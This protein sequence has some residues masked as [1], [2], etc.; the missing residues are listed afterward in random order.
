MKCEKSGLD[1]SRLQERR[2][3]NKIAMTT[4]QQE[5]E[6]SE[7]D[8]HGLDQEINHDVKSSKTMLGSET[9][10]KQQTVNLTPTQVQAEKQEGNVFPYPPDFKQIQERV[11]RFT[12]KPGEEDF[13]VWLADFCEATSDCKWSDVQRAQWFLW[14]LSGAAKST[15][16]RTLHKEEK[17]SWV[18][19]VRVYKGH[20]GVHMEP[21]TAYLRCHEL[22]YEDFLSVKGLLGSMKDYQRMA[23]EQLSDDNLLS[24]LW[25]KAPY[26]LQKEVGDIKDWSL[27]ELFER[28]V[29]AEAR[30]TERDRRVKADA[31]RKTRKNMGM[32]EEEDVTPITTQRKSTTSK[33]G[34]QGS[35][36]TPVR[37][38]KCFKCHHKG[39]VARDCPQTGTSA[40]VIVTTEGISSDEECWI[41]VGVLTAGSEP[42]K[43]AVSNAGPTYKVEV[44]VE[45]LKSR[46]LVDNGSQISLVRTEMLPKLKEINGWSLE[47]CRS[48]TSKVCSQPLGAGGNKLG[49]KKIVILSVTLE[50]TGQVLQLPCYVVDST[51]PLW[52][53]A[54]TV[55]LCL[56]LMP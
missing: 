36:E 44:T 31:T 13:E 22:R 54:R 47:E 53:G 17:K 55:G 34:N 51:R 48:K 27:Q 35:A 40:R 49:A 37:N 50:A 42:E 41:R 15:W 9:R 25:N 14:F 1:I 5:G 52:Q 32:S 23:P 46:A 2:L 45:G 6:W 24:I 56:A 4:L 33:Q 28:L 29:R 39:H 8:D 12:G 26:R 7:D 11:G 16:Q 21:H 38:I 30:L 3:L 20:Y 19:I 43:T 10:A 18:D